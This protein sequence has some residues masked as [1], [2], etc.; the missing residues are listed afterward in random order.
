LILASEL[1]IAIGPEGADGSL[2]AM[3]VEKP[4][5]ALAEKKYRDQ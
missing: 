4:T 2:H 5:A 1:K 3:L